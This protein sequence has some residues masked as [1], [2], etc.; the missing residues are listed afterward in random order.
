MI[1]DISKHKQDINV[2]ID[3]N[4]GKSLIYQSISII[5]NRSI[6]VI[7]LIITFIED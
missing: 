6:L 7:L 5:I 4:T 2:I 1:I 3:I